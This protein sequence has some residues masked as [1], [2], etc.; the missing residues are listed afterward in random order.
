MLSLQTP[1][2][3]LE[4]DQRSWVTLARL[5]RSDYRQEMTLRALGTALLSLLEGQAQRPVI[6]NCTA[7]QFFDS[8][9]ISHL[10]RLRRLLLAQGSRL[11]L[12][13]LSAPVAELLNRLRLDRYFL[14]CRD[15]REALAELGG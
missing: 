11:V 13:D 3:L 6:L 1:S 9:F 10:L 7:P 4:L 15:E 5:L 12:C 8:T 14:I 2:P